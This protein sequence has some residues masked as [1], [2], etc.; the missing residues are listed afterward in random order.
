M[1]KKEDNSDKYAYLTGEE[2]FEF[3]EDNDDENN[4][5]DNIRNLNKQ[6]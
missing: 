5:L 4:K 3:S 6:H 1:P 2:D